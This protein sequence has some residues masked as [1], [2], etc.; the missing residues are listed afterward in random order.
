MPTICRA[1]LNRCISIY[2]FVHDRMTVFIKHNI[3]QIYQIGYYQSEY[4]YSMFKVALVVPGDQW[5]ILGVGN[6]SD[7]LSQRF[8]GKCKFI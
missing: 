7:R 1:C 2:G 3:F 8:F 4:Q 6:K 5:R